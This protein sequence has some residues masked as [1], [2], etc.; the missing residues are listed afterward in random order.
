MHV[1]VQWSTLRDHFFRYLT[2]SCSGMPLSNATVTNSS[3]E[4]GFT[5]F[6]HQRQV[7][8][9]QTSSI[10]TRTS[11]VCLRMHTHT[12]LQREKEQCLSR[13]CPG[14]HIPEQR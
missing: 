5:T 3:D 8:Y 13:K 1:P 7:S 12:S 14:A 4:N 11:F 2:S 10:M 6:H 9:T